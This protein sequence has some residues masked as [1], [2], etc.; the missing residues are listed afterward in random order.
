MRSVV[1]LLMSDEIIQRHAGSLGPVLKAIRDE[2]HAS[3][4]SS[5]FTSSSQEPF[6]EPIPYFVNSL[7][8]D[9][10][11]FVFAVGV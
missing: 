9:K 2:L 10:E 4:F 1:V 8:M 5:Q 3:I 6:V 11:K 7:R